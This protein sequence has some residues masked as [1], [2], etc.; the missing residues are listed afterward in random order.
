MN[1]I[2]RNKKPKIPSYAI[3]SDE[4]G[5]NGGSRYGS[6]S[7]VSIRY[8]LVTRY[9]SELEKILQC[10][11]TSEFKWNKLNGDSSQSLIAN[12]FLDFVESKQGNLRI[13][14]IIWDKM[15]SRHQ[16]KRIDKQKNVQLMYFNLG[17]K[18]FESWRDT[19]YGIE[20]M[21][22][23]LYLDEGSSMNLE[24]VKK[25]HNAS[26]YKGAEYNGYLK[27]PVF[28]ACKYTEQQSLNCPLI[29]LADLFAGLIIY[30]KDFKTDQNNSKRDK[31][32]Q[33]VL[34]KLLSCSLGIKLIED[35][36]YANNKFINFWNYRPQGDYDKAP[37]KNSIT[38]L[39]YS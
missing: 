3:F 13:K 28:Y 14:T 1:V 17:C 31:A 9:L 7:M 33:F 2:I 20:T 36:L 4:S 29:Q 21:Y 34:Q 25:F 26:G 22:W 5:I 19:V 15:D 27:T 8:G 23:N 38:T 12:K 37:T 16:V 6:I 32:R 35:G 11:N 30:A 39:Q 18:V 24:E 10:N